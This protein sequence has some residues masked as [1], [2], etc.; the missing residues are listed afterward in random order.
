[1][2]KYLTKTSFS[3][4]G[5]QALLKEGG[6]SRQKLVKDMAARLGGNIEC[7]Y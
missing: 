6:T 4:S 1:M 2:A 7:F 5:T 3:A